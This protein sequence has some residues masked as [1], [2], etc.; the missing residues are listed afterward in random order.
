MLYYVES[1]YACTWPHVPPNLTH[2]AVDDYHP[3]W[4]CVR[5]PAHRPSP[6]LDFAAYNAETVKR[7]VFRH[8]TCSAVCGCNF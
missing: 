1:D 8:N 7:N 2:F 5:N 4:M 6:V 3:S